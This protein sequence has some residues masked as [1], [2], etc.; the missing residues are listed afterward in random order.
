MN[1]THSVY[2]EAP[3]HYHTEKTSDWYWALGILA[4][5]GSITSIMI[6]NVLLGMLIL[7]AAVTMIIVTQRHPRVIPFEIS[8]RGVRVNTTLY[9]YA[10]LD[11]YFLDEF[12]HVNPQ[13]IIK[14]KKVFMPLI[15]IPIPDEYITEIEGLV[16]AKLPEEH[17][18]EPFGHKLLEYLGF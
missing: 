7:L 11:S 10:T 2:W 13:L 8:I 17:L 16:S 6:G 5:A 18:E 14:S 9:P 4:S 1:E 12:N 3:E 15:V